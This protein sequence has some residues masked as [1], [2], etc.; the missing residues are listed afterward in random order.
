MLTS[1]GP[2]QIFGRKNKTLDARSL[3]DCRHD[4][5]HLRYRDATVEIMLRFDQ[6]GDAGRTLIEAT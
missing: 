2:R 1:L 4:L 5:R 3:C 6:N